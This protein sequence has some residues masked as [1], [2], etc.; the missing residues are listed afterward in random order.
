MKLFVS[1]KCLNKKKLDLGFDESAIFKSFNS[2]DIS[3]L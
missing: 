3:V 1:S 2:P